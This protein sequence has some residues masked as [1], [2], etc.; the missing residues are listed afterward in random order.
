MKT[1]TLTKEPKKV[2]KIITLI[3]NGYSWESTSLVSSKRLITKF[4]LK[5]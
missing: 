4:R 5:K 3:P 2:V 1:L